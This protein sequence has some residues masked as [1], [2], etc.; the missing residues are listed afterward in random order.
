VAGPA[1]HQLR[2][3]ARPDPD[4]VPSARPLDVGD[5]GLR[6][7]PANGDRVAHDQAPARTAAELTEPAQVRA[8]LADTVYH[9]G[10][11]DVATGAVGLEAELLPFW[12]TRDGRPA[13]RLALVEIVGIVGEIPGIVRRPDTGGRPSWELDGVLVTEEPGAQVELAGPPEPDAN[14][15]IAGLE[16][17]LGTVAAAF[18]EAGAGLAAAGLDLWSDHDRIPVQL[19]VPRY[20]AMTAYFAAR[21]GPAGHLLMCASCSLQINVDL[22]PPEVAA[23]RWLLAN[24][25]APVLTA[26]FATSPIADGVNGRALGWRAL[27]PTRTGV[28]PPLISGDDD[29]LEHATVDALRADVL[30]VQ[31]DGEA[32]PGRPGWT[33]GDWVATPD[34]RFGRPTTADLAVHLSTLFPEARLRGYLEVRSVDVL[35]APWR[36][37]AVALVVGLLYDD[38]ATRAAVE[39][40]APCRADLPDLLTRAARQGLGD[41]QLR[42]LSDDLLT[43]G[44]QGAVRLGI[45]A[46]DAAAAYLDRYVRAGRH[47]GDDL[48]HA[49]TEGPAASFAW[50]RA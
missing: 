31:R 6:S 39:R 25:A 11:D 38:D 17:T 18:A 5:G 1:R 30:L 33:F 32:S 3:T 45:E 20:R 4:E 35:P 42:R 15:A 24:L 2:S 34:P 37:A 14:T 8:W 26:A 19:D 22:G 10:P 21:G 48:Q 9:P 7:V 47:P 43:I 50:A 12:V 44:L 16:R 41:P 49:L 28:A 40:L 23:R 13:A 29:P 36:A 27:D 46:A